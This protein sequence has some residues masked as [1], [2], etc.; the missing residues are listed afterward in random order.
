MKIVQ[1]LTSGKVSLQLGQNEK[2]DIEEYVEAL[3]KF[4]AEQAIK[5]H[6]LSNSYKKLV[7][8]L[9]AYERKSTEV[10]K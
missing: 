3:A 1:D 7:E 9:E 5:I 4:V 6:E 2:Y 8:R 10:N